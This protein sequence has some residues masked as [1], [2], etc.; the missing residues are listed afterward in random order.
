MHAYAD[1]AKQLEAKVKLVEQ[2]D[3]NK[4]GE[5]L[6]ALGRTE[7]ELQKLLQMCRSLKQHVQ[8]QCPHDFGKCQRLDSYDDSSKVRYCIECG[9]AAYD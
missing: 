3:M 2:G 7:R 9:F 1:V 4:I 6:N 5:A 8:K